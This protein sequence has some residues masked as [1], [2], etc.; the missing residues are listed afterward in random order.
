MK[1]PKYMIEKMHK[2]NALI[3]EGNAL[4]SEIQNYYREK[5]ATEETIDKIGELE[6]P[7]YDCTDEIIELLQREP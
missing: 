4:I 5:G 6:T 7:Y 2:A 1:I 3:S